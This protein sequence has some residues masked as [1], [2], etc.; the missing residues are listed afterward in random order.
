[1]PIASA[2]VID[3]EP[4]MVLLVSKVLES[5]GFELLATAPD[6]ARGLEEVARHLPDIALVDLNMPGINGVQLTRQISEASPKT[7][8]VILTGV[9]HSRVVDEC[10]QA[11]AYHY[12]VKDDRITNLGERLAEQWEEYRRKTL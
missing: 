7:M 3:D 10:L 6:A 11:G 9:A 5:S 2:I 8:V 12:F 4:S 1:M